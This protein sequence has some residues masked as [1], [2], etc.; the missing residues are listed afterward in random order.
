MK[1]QRANFCGPTMPRCHNFRIYTRQPDL[2]TDIKLNYI[3][4]YGFLIVD[5][6]RFQ[7]CSQLQTCTFCL[8]TFRFKRIS[9]FLRVRTSHDVAPSLDKHEF[10]EFEN[11]QNLK[12]FIRKICTRIRRVCSSCD[13]FHTQKCFTEP[14]E[15]ENVQRDE[16]PYQELELTHLSAR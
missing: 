1:N 3:D 4:L 2:N 14:S 5:I 10:T 9:L 12:T 11:L 13:F 7:S 8:N 16:S 15:V 6:R